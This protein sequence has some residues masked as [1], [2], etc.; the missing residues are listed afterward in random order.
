MAFELIS[1]RVIIHASREFSYRTPSI[2]RIMIQVFH[3][4][5]C[6]TAN[7]R[8]HPFP[9]PR[10]NPLCRYRSL[11]VSSMKEDQKKRRT[12]QLYG[13][14]GSKTLL[15][16]GVTVETQERC[17]MVECI[18]SSFPVHAQIS[19]IYTSNFSFFIIYYT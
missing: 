19:N 8:S 10:W 15:I 16:A 5:Y 12:V 2:M 17:Q 14:G 18:L 11:K 13:H 9:T 4:A 7:R 1:Y 6:S 3:N